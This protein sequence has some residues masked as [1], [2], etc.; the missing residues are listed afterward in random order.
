MRYFEK[1]AA[2][3]SGKLVIPTEF[4]VKGAIE[5]FKNFKDLL[6]SALKENKGYV[7]RNAKYYSW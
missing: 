3:R 2:L 1:S 4:S 6:I 7:S 5:K